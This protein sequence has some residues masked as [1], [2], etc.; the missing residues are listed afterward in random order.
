MIANTT[1]R[2]ELDLL[3]DLEE[4]KDTTEKWSPS[5]KNHIYFNKKEGEKQDGTT[6]KKSR[7]WTRF[8]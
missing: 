2:A 5:I 6:I 7:N 1:R 4:K 3:K 8:C